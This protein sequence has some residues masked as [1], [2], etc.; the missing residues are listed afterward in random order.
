VFLQMWLVWC[1]MVTEFSLC[2]VCFANVS[3][4]YSDV[5]YMSLHIPGSMCVGVT[6]WYGWG[7]VVQAETLLVCSV[8][9]NKE[10]MKQVTSSWSLF[11]Q[12]SR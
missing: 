2:V 9:Q 1:L 8:E 11:I 12:L 10:I 3:C 6:L 7:G 4:T 5:I